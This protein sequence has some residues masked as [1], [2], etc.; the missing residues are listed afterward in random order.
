MLRCEQKMPPRQ[1][2]TPTRVPE[3]NLLQLRLG[4][5]RKQ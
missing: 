4:A 5:K 2:A 3:N 1:I